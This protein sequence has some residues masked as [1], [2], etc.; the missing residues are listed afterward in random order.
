ML[1]VNGEQFNCEGDA[2]EFAELLCAGQRVETGPAQ[3][4]STAVVALIEELHNQG[5]LAFEDQS[6]GSPDS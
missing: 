6:E 2:A 3:A 1:F 5:S 4:A